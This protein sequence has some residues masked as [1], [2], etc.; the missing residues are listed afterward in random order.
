MSEIKPAITID[1]VLALLQEHFA[2]PVA[3]LAPIETGQVA[4]TFSLLRIVITP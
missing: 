3:G 4:R 2:S 1:Q